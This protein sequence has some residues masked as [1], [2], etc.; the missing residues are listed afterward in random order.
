MNFSGYFWWIFL[1]SCS[2]FHFALCFHSFDVFLCIRVRF[3]VFSLLIAL[4]RS[5]FFAIA[6]ALCFRH[7]C[8]FVFCVRVRS[9]LALAFS[10]SLYR[11]RLQP[12][13]NLNKRMIHIHINIELYESSRRKPGWRFT[14]GVKFSFTATFCVFEV[15]KLKFPV[16]VI[17]HSQFGIFP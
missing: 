15:Q 3:R 16:F 8:F 17:A 14:A 13:I 2:L 7:F 11:S 12:Y 9:C 4:S 5:C 1:C 6:L 10:L